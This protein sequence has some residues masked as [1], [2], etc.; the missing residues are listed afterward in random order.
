MAHHQVRRGNKKVGVND[1]EMAQEAD[2][3]V[4]DEYEGA[5]LPYLQG[6][7]EAIH[8]RWKCKKV[9]VENECW[10]RQTSG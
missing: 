4:D 7:P 8:L 6:R 3:T 5:P 9:V 1:R 10:R 2:V